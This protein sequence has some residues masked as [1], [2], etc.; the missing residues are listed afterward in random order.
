MLANGCYARQGAALLSLDNQKL[1]DLNM[2]DMS[3]RGYLRQCIK[4]EASKQPASRVAEVVQGRSAATAAAA[5]GGGGVAATAAAASAA[6]APA[7][8]G[9]PTRGRGQSPEDA[10]AV[11]AL[12]DLFPDIS[13]ETIV[14]VLTTH[15][16]AQDAT[17]TL[18]ACVSLHLPPQSLD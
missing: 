5:G 9:S 13:R 10:G 16:S 18:C 17:T 4:A 1:I 3:A 12:M 2:F 11:Q 8:T 15:G 14:K 6:P 7:S